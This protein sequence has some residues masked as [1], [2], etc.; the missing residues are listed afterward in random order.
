MVGARPNQPSPCQ[1]S[2]HPISQRLPGVGIFL[3]DEGTTRRSNQMRPTQRR[4]NRY[5]RT[6]FVVH[7]KR[8]TDR[9]TTTVECMR[10]K[11]GA[12]TAHQ[13]NRQCFHFCR[14]LLS[15]R[16]GVAEMAGMLKLLVRVFR[17][18]TE[19]CR[20]GYL[21]GDSLQLRVGDLR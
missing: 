17:K 5:L 14:P 8:Q 20:D 1:V 13:K 2:T 19:R 6:L 11:H 3:V 12:T 9:G 7:C 18:M 16:G 10:T 15:G 21:S 4:R